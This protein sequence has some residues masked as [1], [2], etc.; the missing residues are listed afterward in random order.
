MRKL[1]IVI[2]STPFLLAGCKTID[3]G[4]PPPP[5]D[6]LVCKAIPEIPQTA[7]LEAVT[8]GGVKYYRKADVDTRDGVIGDS[9]LE[10]RGVAFDCKSQLQ[11]NRDYH[12]GN[13]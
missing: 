3:V 10:V 1:L 12:A 4:P 7:A 5:A 11:W 2:L 13:E 9:Y 8:F 6:K